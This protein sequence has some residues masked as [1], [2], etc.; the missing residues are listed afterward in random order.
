MKVTELTSESPQVSLVM[1]NMKAYD[2]LLSA[3]AV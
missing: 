3:E 2:R 1:G